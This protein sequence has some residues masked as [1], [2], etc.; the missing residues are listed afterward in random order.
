MPELF[1]NMI[2]DDRIVR[3]MPSP[4]LGPLPQLGNGQLEDLT[5]EEIRIQ[6]D[7]RFTSDRIDIVLAS[8]IL[9]EVSGREHQFYIGGDFSK[10]TLCYRIGLSL[11]SKLQT[12][13]PEVYG[14][15]G[16]SIYWPVGGS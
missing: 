14:T 1:G 4:F 10:A 6:H 5:T 7:A 3:C 8:Q 16:D 15:P 13:H 12:V 11:F 2:F 9:E